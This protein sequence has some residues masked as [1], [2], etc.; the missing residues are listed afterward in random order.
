MSATA[1]KPQ[2]SQTPLQAAT[3]EYIEQAAEN[4]EQI[5]IGNIVLCE[6][7]WV[8]ESAYGYSRMDIESLLEK[9]LQTNTFAF[10]SKDLIWSAF[11]DFRISKVDFADCLM[12]R[13]HRAAGCEP[14]V[15]FDAALRKL[16]TFKVL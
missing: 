5:L 16:P 11:T 12:G 10:E 3:A 15:T 7:V 6:T 14:T 13:I 9:L 8:L 4:A 2:A 1:D